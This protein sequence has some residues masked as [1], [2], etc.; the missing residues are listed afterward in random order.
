MYVTK[1]RTDNTNKALWLEIISIFPNFWK[2]Q[3]IT[4]YFKTI[5]H[6]IYLDTLSLC[7]IWCMNSHRAWSLIIV[8]GLKPYVE[9]LSIIIVW[10]LKLHVGASSFFIMLYSKPH[11]KASSFRNVSCSKPQVEA[12]SII[13]MGCSKPQVEASSFNIM[14]CSKPL[15]EALSII[16]MECSKPQVEAPSF[17]ITLCSKPYVII[18]GSSKLRDEVPNIAQLLEASTFSRNKNA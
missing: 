14:L 18:V 3:F 7:D 4:K 16:I 1:S 10:C 2:I 9:A 12:S 6:Q 5:F 8:L 11:V 13:I 15:V 17:I